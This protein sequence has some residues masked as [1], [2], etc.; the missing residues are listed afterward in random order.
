M[1]G[2]DGFGTELRRGDGETEESFTAIGNVGNFSG[3]EMEREAYDVTAHDG[4]NNYREF[5]GG[6]VNGGEVSVEVHYD[7]EKH[8]QFAEDFEN[9][10]PINY[11]MESPVGEVW[12]FSA[13]LTGF[14]REMPIDEQMSAELTWQVSGKPEITPA[15]P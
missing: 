8:D 12:A 6:L 13:V 7:P 2:K 5:I 14:S 1:A 4:P 9:P 11:E 3:P 15:A 10:N